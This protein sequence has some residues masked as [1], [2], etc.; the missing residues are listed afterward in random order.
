MYSYLRVG[1]AERHRV[2]PGGR[3]SP[4]ALDSCEQLRE[5][6]RDKQRELALL[7]AMEGLE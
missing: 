1:V 7:L 6:L 4:C 3:R 2:L 5:Q